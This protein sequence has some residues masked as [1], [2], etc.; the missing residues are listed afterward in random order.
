M[1]GFKKVNPTIKDS[2]K[3]NFLRNVSIQIRFEE[4][5]KI[6]EQKSVI[7]SI[8]ETKYPRLNDV[9]SNEVEIQIK[10]ETPIVNTIKG[11]GFALRTN[12]G[13]K[14]LTFSNTSVDLSINGIGYK[15]FNTI[16]NFE[17][18][19]ICDLL[20][21]NSVNVVDR[22]AIRKINI[23]GIVINE[24]TFLAQISKELLNESI[25]HN[26]ECF[27]MEEM[28]NQN[29]NNVNYLNGKNGLNLKLG[30][31]V[32]PKNPKLGHLICDIDRFNIDSTKIEDIKKIFE[33]INNEIF[34]VFMWFL[35]EKSI[36]ILTTL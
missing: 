2:F 11:K 18:K 29:I 8:F 28:I 26:F 10:N 3:R 5:E 24:D 27:P 9:I 34:D 36:K 13:N 32:Q 35:N 6:L 17:L 22:I 14:T 23:V 20:S 15:N 21:R 33:D 19:E 31:T 16:L 1:F 4:S 25:Y 7:H 30:Y 12:D